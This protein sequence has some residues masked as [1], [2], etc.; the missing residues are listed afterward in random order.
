MFPMHI[1]PTCC[2]NKS[3]F[4]NRWWV[5]NF[6]YY[7]DISTY[8]I[9]MYL[10]RIFLNTSHD[11]LFCHQEHIVASNL[12]LLITA[13]AE[14]HTCIKSIGSSHCSMVSC[15][16]VCTY[17]G[18]DYTNRA[19]CDSVIAHLPTL[20][21]WHQTLYGLTLCLIPKCKEKSNDIFDRFLVLET[22]W[23][24]RTIWDCLAMSPLSLISS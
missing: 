2:R 3:Y 4:C 7:V 21:I 23:R 16:H 15:Y 8:Q 14:F 18:A 10:S 17:L 6:T 20:D 24:S 9:S 5:E 13:F 1:V 11:S 19:A 22:I 12:C